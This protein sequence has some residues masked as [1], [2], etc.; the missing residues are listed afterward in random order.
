M[1]AIQGPKLGPRNG[2]PATHSASQTRVNALLLSRG[3]PRG[4]ERQGA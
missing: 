1:A 3:A 4:D 2:V